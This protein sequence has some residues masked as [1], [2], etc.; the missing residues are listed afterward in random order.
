MNG[1]QIALMAVV[2]ASGQK[3][4]AERFHKGLVEALSR[5]GVDTE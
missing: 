4:G 1:K 5:Y 3:G 2:P